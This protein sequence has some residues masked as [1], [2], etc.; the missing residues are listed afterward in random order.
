MQMCEGH[1]SDGYSSTGSV[2]KVPTMNI[3]KFILK[4][5]LAIIIVLLIT[6]SLNMLG[7]GIYNFFVT[8]A[9]SRTTFGKISLLVSFFAA[10]FIYYKFISGTAI[11]VRKG[12]K[13][14]ED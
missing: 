8:D 9:S 1:L 2:R 4:S 10:N 11:G 5:I 14:K 3:A 13:S 7:A 12:P 6:T